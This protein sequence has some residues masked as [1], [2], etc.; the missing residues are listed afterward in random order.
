MAAVTASSFFFFSLLAT[1]IGFSSARPQL[2]REHGGCTVDLISFSPCLP[3]VA[4]PPNY[5]SSSPPPRCC[6][7]YSATIDTGNHASC[8]CYLRREPSML[9][10][11]LNV[12]RL[13]SL[14]SICP[15][16]RTYSTSSR[17]NSTLASICS[18]LKALSPLQSTGAGSLNHSNAGPQVSPPPVAGLTP[19]SPESPP[20]HPP[21]SGLSE[22]FPQ[23]SSSR[24]IRSSQKWFLQEDIFVFVLVSALQISCITET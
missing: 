17:S 14:S 10:F 2:Q 7:V 19:N 3:Y 4:A 8:L 5:A 13:L 6:A 20:P 21:S 15:R 1:I 24:K 22:E 16:N 9:G 23:D 11:P 18:D 12:S